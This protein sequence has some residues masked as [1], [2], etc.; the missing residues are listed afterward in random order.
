MLDIIYRKD[1]I[2]IP[3]NISY[4]GIPFDL[5]GTTIKFI[6]KK[7]KEDGSPIILEK[8]ITSHTDPTAG[9]SEIVLTSIDTNITPGKY[10]YAIVLVDVIGKQSTMIVS[11]IEIRQGLM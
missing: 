3:F 11:D 5:S 6:L 7:D 4:D 8:T 1:D 9:K 10:Y 2:V